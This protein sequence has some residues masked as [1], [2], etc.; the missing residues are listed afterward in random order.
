MA[1]SRLAVA[2]TFDEVLAS[3]AGPWPE[4]TTGTEVMVERMAIAAV[5]VLNPKDFLASEQLVRKVLEVALALEAAVV[6]KAAELPESCS[7]Q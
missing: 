6:G 4:A 1:A 7:L 2:I 3:M 5:Q